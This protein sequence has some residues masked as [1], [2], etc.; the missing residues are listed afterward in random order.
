MIEL[1]NLTKAFRY[2]GQPKYIVR[3]AS[4]VFP[5][6]TSVALM[7]RNGVGKSTLLQ[8]IAGTMNPDS[9]RVRSEGLVSWPI[10]L[11]GCIHPE[12]T[13]VQNVRFIAR[14]YGVDTDE[15][16]DFVREFAEL[17]NNYYQPTRNYSSGQRARLNFGMSMAIRF[18]CY[19]IDEVT[20]VGDS[21]FKAK[22]AQLFQD[23]MANSGAIYVSHS[24]SAMRQT[25]TAGIVLEGGKLTYFDDIEEAIDCHERNLLGPS[26][27]RIRLLDPD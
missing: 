24:T 15:M 21:S 20:A 10:G 6:G 22:S 17:G 27:K 26:Y 4:A 2:K 25:C 14:V 19:L 11:A 9:G 18:D 16:V 3:D 8:L 1:V 13:G 5:S 7:G 12:L 23:R